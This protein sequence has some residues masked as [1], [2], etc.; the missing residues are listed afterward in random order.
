MLSQNLK[1]PEPI[2]ILKP[3]SPGRRS[4]FNYGVYDIETPGKESLDFHSVGFFDGEKYTYYRDFEEFLCNILTKKYSGWRFFA[5]FGGRFDVHY[6]YDWMR[7]NEPKTSMEINCAGSCVISLTI[8]QG[9]Y[10]WRF[11]DSYRLLPKSLETL[12]NDFDVE[13]KKLV[14]RDFTDSLYNEHDCRGLHEVLEQFFDTFDI[15]SETIASHAMRVF[16]SHFLKRELWQPHREVEEFVRKAYTGGRCE[17]F[18]YDRADLNHYDVNSLFPTAMLEPVP[19]EYLFQSRKIPDDDSEFIGFYHARVDYPETYLPSLPYKAEKLYFPVGRFEGHFTSIDLRKAIEQGARVKIL[20]GR[21]F[22]TEPILADYATTL[23]KMKKSA[24]V[25]GDT[26]RRQIAKILMNSL[27]GK[28]AQRRDQKTYIV[29]DGRIGVYP[30]PGGIAWY[31]TESRAAHILPHIAATITSRARD[32]QHALLSRARN[33][34]TDT[35]SLFTDADY[36]VD[37]ALGALHFEGRGKFQAYRLK[38]YF[39]REAYKIKG[40]QRSKDPDKKKRAVEDKR[41]AEKYLAG[42]IIPQERMVGWT[43]SVRAG[44]PTV[45]RVVRPRFRREIRDKR[46]RDGFDSRPWNVSELQKET[47]LKACK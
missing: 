26:G 2:I 20:S 5:H 32:I 47:A 11:T 46:A 3:L 4:R 13:H 44:K 40:L 16:R 21:I 10:R 45:R 9:D 34:Y 35:D 19:I 6:V 15:C 27:Y 22:K 12:T 43:E 33:W 42:E 23:F 18:R 8:R 36:P 37:D 31:E 7:A 14:G 39:F 28:F 24:D 41:L 38:E 17:I 25:A 30:L 1:N 29:D